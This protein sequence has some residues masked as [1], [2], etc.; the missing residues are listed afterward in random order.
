MTLFPLMSYAQVVATS[1][2]PSEVASQVI[3][4]FHDDDSIHITN[5]NDTEGTWIHVQIFR[6]ADTDDDNDIDILCDERNFIDFLTPNDTHFYD[7]EDFPFNKNMGETETEFGEE[8]SIN[9]QD[10]SSDGYFGFVIITPVVSES[11]LTA[12]SFHYLTGNMDSNFFTSYTNAIG[13]DAV[14]FAT[15]DR[16]EDGIPLDGET[17][18]FVLLQPAENLFLF[19][20]VSSD[21]TALI[22]FAFEDVYGD[23]GLLGYTVNPASFTWTSFL[24]DFKEDPTS[25]GTRT[26]E[27]FTLLGIEEDDFG[28]ITDDFENDLICGGADVP[29]NADG[30]QYGWMRIF[31]S[32][33]GDNVNHLGIFGVDTEFDAEDVVWMYTR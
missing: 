21:T 24:F 5:T 13:R 8:V 29:A 23:P 33:L 7:F 20:D 2:N 18:G 17:N 32:G 1:G 6:T 22:G 12:K 30:D 11:D 31:V 4:L 9:L 25:C 10:L 16:I 19:E 15:G 3:Y 26:F 14:D 27:C 28:P